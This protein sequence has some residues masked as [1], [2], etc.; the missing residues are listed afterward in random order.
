MRL[1]IPGG[2]HCRPLSDMFKGQLSIPNLTRTRL[3][4]KRLDPA[5]HTAVLNQML[6]CR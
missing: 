2:K 3:E 6:P 5:D 4:R 1:A